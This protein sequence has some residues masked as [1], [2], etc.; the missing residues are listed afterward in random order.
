[1]KFTPGLK[2]SEPEFG[3]RAM[4]FRRQILRFVGPFLLGEGLGKLK[5]FDFWTQEFQYLLC[6]PALYKK[7]AVYASRVVMQAFFETYYFLFFPPENFE[8]MN[9]LFSCSGRNNIMCHIFI[10]T[11]V[12]TI[13][14]SV[15][16]PN[17]Y[18]HLSKKN[19]ICTKHKN[20]LLLTLYIFAHSII[21]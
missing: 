16:K 8:K 18:Y 2:Y 13:Q 3:A 17:N 6:K 9:Y 12:N 20:Y 7:Y 19:V 4:R 5:D 21:H 15:Q 14:Q 10:L 1:M 11:T